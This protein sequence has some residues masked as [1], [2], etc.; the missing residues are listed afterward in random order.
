MKQN[1]VAR[2]VLNSDCG[3]RPPRPASGKM[4]SQSTVPG[5][6]LSNGV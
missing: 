6:L 4:N 1:A 5:A 2:F 3:M